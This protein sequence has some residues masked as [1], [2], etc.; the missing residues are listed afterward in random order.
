MQV[1][2]NEINAL[3]V[4]TWRWLGVNGDITELA[5]PQV[6]HYTGKP[7]SGKVPAGAEI[8]NIADGKIVFM[9]KEADLPQNPEVLQF[10]K[11]NRS[12]GFSVRIAPNGRVDEPIVFDYR[13]NAQNPA[14]VDENLIVA[15]EGSEATVVMHYASDDD[16]E[17]F[18]CGLTKVIAK[19]NA[20]VKLVQVQTL[21]DGCDH[22]DN[23][24]ALALDGAHIEVVQAELGGRRAFANCREKLAGERSGLDMSAVYLGDGSR[25][26]DFNVVAEHFGKRSQSSITAH[27]A[28]FGS[29]RKIFR[30]TIDFKKGA[31]GSRG[32]EE[33]NTML[34]GPGVRSRTAPLILC[35]EEDVDGHHAASVGHIDEDRM[36]YLMSRGLN[37]LEA[38]KLLIEAEFE[39]VTAKIPVPAFRQEI[40]DFLKGRLNRIESI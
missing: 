22:F 33:E 32:R 14:V 2:W 18:H 26:I 6:K 12:A 39:P 5:V 37:E 28:L 13:I 11:K 30:G 40:S 24:S 34:L 9:D 17:G 38:K 7:F 10:I 23:V 21:G 35:A 20:K 15:E 27:G 4:K 29:S 25:E 31:S 19:K 3:P 8:Y 36:F 1:K 16:A